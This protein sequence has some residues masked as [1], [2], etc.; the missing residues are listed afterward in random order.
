MVI[1]KF[2]NGIQE[3]NLMG[4]VLK[5]LFNGEMEAVKNLMEFL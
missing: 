5:N 1:A 3:M 4:G 2:H